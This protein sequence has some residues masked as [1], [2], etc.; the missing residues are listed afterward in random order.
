[1]DSDP[2]NKMAAYQRN[3]DATDGTSSYF[4]NE[5]SHRQCRWPIIRSP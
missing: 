4:N 5:K 3:E 1:M 2:I